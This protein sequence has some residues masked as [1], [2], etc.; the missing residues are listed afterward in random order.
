MNLVAGW[1]VD[2]PFLTAVL[3]VIGF[4]VN[5]TIVIFDRIRENLHRHR[6]ESFATVT[7]RS[8]LETMQRSISTQVTAMLILVALIIFGGV[9]LR[10]F[11][12]T[13]LVGLISGTYSSIF[14]AAPVVVAWEEKQLLGKP[15]QAKANSVVVTA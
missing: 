3:T 13:L 9:T 6:G 14:N 1:E 10:V 2:A 11:M 4:S 12:S 15:A 8:L 7:N 5:Y